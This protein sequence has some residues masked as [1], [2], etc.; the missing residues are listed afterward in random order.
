MLTIDMSSVTVDC[1]GEENVAP[2]EKTDLLMGT[3][4]LLILKTLSLGP[5]HGFGVS[6]RIRQIS[7]EVF[8]VTQGSLYPA[9]HRL[10]QD[11]WI[12]SRWGETENRRRAKY[13]RLTEDGH[14]RLEEKT[15]SWRK[16]SGAVERILQVT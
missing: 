16:A 10:E 9:L 1:Q 15:R 4:D 11:G 8:Q 6:V 13:Y 2:L 5:M 7:Q 3:L 14:R 12:S